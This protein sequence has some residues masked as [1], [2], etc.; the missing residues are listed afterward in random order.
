MADNNAFSSRQA[1]YLN[2]TFYERPM[3]DSITKCS[4]D[5][6]KYIAKQ[7]M[8]TN[9]LLSNERQLKERALL[10]QALGNETRLKILGLLSVQELCTCDIVAGLDGATSTI[11]FHLRM[12]E[13]AGL[14]TSRRVSKFTLYQLNGGP[15][16]WHRVFE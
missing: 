4:P 14:V 9:R 3:S 5:E 12:L 11:T 8:T 16:E 2:M 10:F 13:D 6:C 1:G 7:A 15:L